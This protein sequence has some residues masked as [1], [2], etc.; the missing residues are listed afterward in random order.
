MHAAFPFCNEIDSL[1]Y[2]KLVSRASPVEHE[3]KKEEK[4]IRQSNQHSTKCKWRN[5]WLATKE[6]KPI[7]LVAKWHEMRLPKSLK[8]SSASMFQTPVTSQ[9]SGMKMLLR[10]NSSY[11]SI[12][13]TA[14][15]SAT[16]PALTAVSPTY[17]Y[18]YYYYYYY[19]H[20]HHH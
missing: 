4:F 1:W 20:H 2:K 15:R 11:F 13:F 6:G 10:R 5:E 9:A 14:A 18:Y 16:A 17:N 3:K 12:F 19:Y 7:E 8:N